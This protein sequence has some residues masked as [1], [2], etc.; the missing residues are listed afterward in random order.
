MATVFTESILSLPHPYYHYTP[1]FRTVVYSG[2]LRSTE[3]GISFRFPLS[4]TP[5]G[6]PLPPSW[7]SPHSTLTKR[8]TQVCSD[9]PTFLDSIPNTGTIHRLSQECKFPVQVFIRFR[10]R[11]CIRNSLTN[12]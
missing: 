1:L 6:P 3:G 8:L 9:V 12:A 4:S 11:E 7:K 5:P 2:D 10:Q